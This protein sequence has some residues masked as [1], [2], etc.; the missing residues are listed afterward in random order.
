M[1]EDKPP[2]RL[3]EFDARLRRARTEGG[4]SASDA[5]EGAANPMAG[6]GLA[7]RIGV[8]LVAALVVGV[9]IGLLLDNWLET[10]PWFLVAFFFLGAAAGV[11]N[12]YRAASGIG[13]G[14]GYGEPAEGKRQAKK[15]NGDAP[16]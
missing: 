8:E 3:D 10:G 11:L 13:L 12:V 15:D 4:P 2:N 14:P 16:T 1:G 6:F 7:F 5:D 9:G